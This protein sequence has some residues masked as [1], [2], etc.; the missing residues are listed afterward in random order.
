MDII[1]QMKQKAKS[2]P[3]GIR[4]KVESIETGEI[5]KDF[6]CGACQNKADKLESGLLQKTNLDKYH[7]YQ[8]V[9]V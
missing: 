3:K 1:E 6:D 4:V 8:S 2:N 9:T 7:V 5:V